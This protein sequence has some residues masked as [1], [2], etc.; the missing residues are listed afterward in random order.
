M[1]LW[2]RSTA[3]AIGILIAVA[4]AVAAECVARARAKPR[5]T[6]EFGCYTSSADLGITYRPD[7]H[8]AWRGRVEGRLYFDKT[9]STDA[10]GRRV[11]PQLRPEARRRLVIFTGCSFTAGTGANDDETMPHYFGEA[12]PGYRVLNYARSGYGPQQ[13]L[14]QVERYM[15][16][17]ELGPYQGSPLLVYVIISDHLYRAPGARHFLASYGSV[18]PSYALAPGGGVRL[19]G[20]FGSAHPWRTLFAQ[21]VQESALLRRLPEPVSPADVELTGQILLAA[22]DRFS[23]RFG[24]ERFVV[25][26]Y[27]GRRTPAYGATLDRLRQ[28]GVRVLDPNDLLTMSE[29]RALRYPDFHPVPEC[30]RRVGERL[31]TDLRALGWLE[32]PVSPAS[33]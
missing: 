8:T 6:D 19:E 7:C 15:T 23:E 31:A 33:R 26:A 3:L 27:P 20:T 29:R 22:R 4:T 2:P 13:A 10:F 5:R 14:L 1:R 18:Y 12:A 24:S 9:F 16:P 25:L 30:H 21:W 28:L 17:E 32:G 11:T